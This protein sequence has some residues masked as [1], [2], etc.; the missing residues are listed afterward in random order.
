VR[1]HAFPSLHTLPSDFTGFEH[2]VAGSQTPAEW[3][4]SLATQVTGFAPVHSPLWQVSVCVQ[5]LPSSQ[6]VPSAFAGFEHRPVAL[7]QTPTLWHWSD[8][9]Q[10]TG[11]APTQ[12]PARH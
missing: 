10:T 5:T 3:H 6:P 7:L 4:W 8:A 11:F 1:V 2:P 12:P 9:L